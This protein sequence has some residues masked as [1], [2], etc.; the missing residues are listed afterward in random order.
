MNKQETFDKVARLIIAQGRRS[1]K[2]DNCV[3]AGPDGT[4]C[5]IGCLLPRDVAERWDTYVGGHGFSMT[6]V[7]ERDYMR[8]EE[9]EACIRDLEAAGIPTDR[10]FLQRLQ[11][12]HDGAHNGVA[13]KESFKTK[14]EL[15]A[16]DFNLDPSILESVE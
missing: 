13:F 5:A 1:I 2:G 12:A 11:Q 15:L 6:T 10:H 9:Q 7:F 8:R 4:G 16:V 14:M 3:Y